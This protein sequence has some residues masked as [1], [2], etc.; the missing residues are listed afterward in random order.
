MAPARIYGA[1]HTPSGK[2][3]IG[4]TM[5]SAK[6]REYDHKAQAHDIHRSTYPKFHEAIRTTDD[7]EW[8]WGVHEEIDDISKQ[9]LLLL[10]TEYQKAFD[11]VI[12]GFN[13]NYACQLES[14]WHVKSQNS[15]WLED[16][17]KARNAERRVKLQDPMWKE[18][19]KV[20]RRAAYERQ[21]AKKGKLTA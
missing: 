1:Q 12:S 10:E 3:Y 16:Y 4:S 21:K 19:D 2:W 7:S 13:T 15:A 8:I 6:N 18:K 11:S 9:D 14:W 17:R 5:N 20:K